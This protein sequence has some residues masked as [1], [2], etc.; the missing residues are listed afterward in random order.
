MGDIVERGG[1]VDQG[2]DLS[3]CWWQR[4]DLRRGKLHLARRRLPRR[5]RCLGWRNGLGRWLER[6]GECATALQEAERFLVFRHQLAG[7]GPENAAGQQALFGHH[8][9]RESS[10]LA[11]AW[12]LSLKRHRLT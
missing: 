5:F 4:P 12:H 10:R 11:S 1:A 9:L 2:K 6:P 7:K 8:N 3:L